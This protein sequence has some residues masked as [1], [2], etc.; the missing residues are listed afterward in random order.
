MASM[1]RR[2]RES[3]NVLFTAESTLIDGLLL[4]RRR[5]RRDDRGEFT[6]LHCVRDFQE[7]GVLEGGMVQTNLSVT[8]Q[9]GTVRGFHVLREPSREHKLVVCLRGSVWDVALD[10]RDGS[11]TVHRT[12]GI[13]LSEREDVA[14]LV[15]PGVAHGFQSLEPDAMLLYQHSDFYQ[16][17]LDMGVDALDPAIDVSWPLEVSNRSER[18]RAL[19]LLADVTDRWTLR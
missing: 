12:F 16:P 17:E 1:E 10:L 15:P 8:R 6:R 19:P 18:D 2:S 11:P 9:V 3:P 5:P 13:R 7:L 4:V 14:V